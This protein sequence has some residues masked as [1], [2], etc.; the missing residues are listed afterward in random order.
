MEDSI[1]TSNNRSNEM[2]QQMKERSSHESSLENDPVEKNVSGE[3]KAV[4]EQQQVKE[5]SADH[6]EDVPM[7]FPQRVSQEANTG[8]LS[9]SCLIRRSKVFVQNCV[10]SLRSV[11]EGVLLWCN[12]VWTA[13]ITTDA[14]CLYVYRFFCSSCRTLNSSTYRLFLCIGPWALLGKFVWAC[15]PASMFAL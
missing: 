14:K 15:A 10:L 9:S 1:V 8:S 11:V 13:L 6:D 2:E 3:K 12:K 5:S 4:K 7:T